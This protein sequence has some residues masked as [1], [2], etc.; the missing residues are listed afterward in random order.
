MAC[1]LLFFSP[2]PVEDDPRGTRS[3]RFQISMVEG[4]Y[5]YQPWCCCT[6][7]FPC[8]SAY[9]TRYRALEGDMRKYICCQVIFTSLC[10][11]R[12]QSPSVCLSL[13]DI[14]IAVVSELEIVV[15][16][17]VQNF[18]LHWNHFA[19]LVQACHPLESM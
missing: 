17:H 3:N 6:F 13:R 4:L 11:D 16:V 14:S 10:D 2:E 9:Y 1:C 7:L 15:K 18:V 5:N 19:V 8:C 12:S